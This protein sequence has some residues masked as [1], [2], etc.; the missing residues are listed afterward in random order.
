MYSTLK[1]TFISLACKS[2]LLLDS[3]PG[4][5]DDISFRVLGEER[6][7]P[8]LMPRVKLKSDKALERCKTKFPDI[9]LLIENAL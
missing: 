8:L 7:E 2:F 6:Q 9:F 3:S 5:L 4:W 1:K